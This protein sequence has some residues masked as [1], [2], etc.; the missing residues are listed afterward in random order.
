MHMLSRNRKEHFLFFSIYTVFMIWV[1]FQVHTVHE[2]WAQEKAATAAQMKNLEQKQQELQNKYAATE[3]AYQELKKNMQ[4]AKKHND[5]P[6]PGMTLLPHSQGAWKTVEMSA[7]TANCKE[8][9]TGIT[10]TGMDVRDASK[11][12]RIV[13][14][15]PKIIPLYSIIEI[16]GHGYY[17]AMDKGGAIK[18]YKV[19]VLMQTHEQAIQFG[20]K[21]GQFRFIRRGGSS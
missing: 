18:G 11:D 5:T 9:C 15:D 14:V 2:K 19:D 10:A 17:Q 4:Q 16:K 13:A 7:Y 3:K 6:K 12:H 21:Y 8:G 20:R 1:F